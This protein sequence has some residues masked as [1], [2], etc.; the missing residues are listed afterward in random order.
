M[1]SCSAVNAGKSIETVTLE[2]LQSVQSGGEDEELDEDELDDDE[3]QHS[4]RPIFSVVVFKIRCPHTAAP[5]SSF[6]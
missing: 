2:G 1:P 3:P 5:I 4:Q 6:L